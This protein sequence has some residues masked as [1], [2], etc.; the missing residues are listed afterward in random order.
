MT[1][2]NG[3]WGLEF[4]GYGVECGWWI[5]YTLVKNVLI[6]YFNVATF[7]NN[8]VLFARNNISLF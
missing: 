4:W 5:V 6:E 2:S 1:S 8:L 3:V 7:S